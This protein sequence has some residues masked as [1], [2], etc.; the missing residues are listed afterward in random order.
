[1]R[2]L[3]FVLIGLISAGGLRLGAETHTSR[4]PGLREPATVRR[5]GRGIPYI[6]AASETDLMMAQGYVTA[7]DRLWQMDLLRRSSRG[8]LAE[9]FG[10]LALEEDKRHRR[11]GFG[12][13]AEAQVLACNPEFRAALEA[14]AR[15]VNLYIDS[16]DEKT[17]PVEFRILK[18]RPTPWGPGDSLAIGCLMSESLSTSWRNDIARTSMPEIPAGKLK[19]LM[20]ERSPLDVIVV[21]SDT[22]APSAR[23]RGGRRQA[24]DSKIHSLLDADAEIERRT[25]ERAGLY[26]EGLAASNNWVVDGRHSV[27]GKPLLANDPHLSPTAPSIWHLVHLGAPGFRAAGVTFPGVP[28]VVL[29]HNERIAWGATNLGPDVQDLYREQFD[30][31]NPR[32]YRTPSG[33]KDAGI[34]TELIRVR[35]SPLEPATETVELEVTITRH[36]PVIFERGEGAAA[37]RYALNWTALSA[38]G[39]IATTF[40]RLDRA[41][42]WKEFCDALRGYPGPTQN[43]VY[44]DVDGHIGYYGAGWIPIRR[45]GDGSTPYDG[46]TDDGEWT[47]FIPFEKLPHVLD[48]PSGIIA[49]ANSRVVG[50]D[51]PYHLTHDWAEPYRARR[52]F[53]LLNAR[54]KLSVDDMRDIHSDV[55]SIS[56]AS[57]A[58]ELAAAA[59][60]ETTAPAGDPPG[61]KELPS[62][63]AA[64]DGRMSG[65]SR[66]ALV[67]AET[68]SAFRLRILSGAMGGERAREFRW[69]S[70]TFVDRVVSEKPKEWLPA[71]VDS[72]ATLLRESWRDARTSLEKRL[73][74]D[75]SKWVWGTANAPRWWRH[76]LADAPLIGGQFRVPAFQADGN[77]GGLAT[78]NVGPAVSMRLI[79]DT[80]DWDNSR[81][82]LA[83]GNSGDPAN[84]HWK[85][86][87]EIWRRV[88]PVKLP[89]SAPEVR[90][91]AQSTLTLTP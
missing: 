84:P 59:R 40:F 45:S 52:I 32:R 53:D 23:P 61:W 10:K 63:L 25:L 62:L 15:G 43:F 19:E 51:Y 24:F 72:Y 7:N 73:G 38:S 5:D 76:P 27:T 2:R 60:A 90:G 83:P 89:F 77:G 9:I 79:A 47:G 82:H 81:Q 65:D 80:A 1:M 58:K 6:E 35:K 50:L 44:A 11:L 13:V 33:W 20:P 14:Y 4:L 69:G 75:D 18:Y 48:P 16:L 30:P 55:F 28:G 3:A 31:Q 22:R 34:R 66:A 57:F 71:G 42:N 68:R 29:G 70:G 39:D 49:T 17:L 56:G 67:V 87:L 64:W 8:E 85:D 78:V 86:Q 46:S 37:E 88:T 74:P 36:G 12:R 41:R 91:A 26:A 54:P 21:G